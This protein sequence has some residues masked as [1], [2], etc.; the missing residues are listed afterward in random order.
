LKAK[1]NLNVALA[2]PARLNPRDLFNDLDN[3][4]DTLGLNLVQLSGLFNSQA[5]VGLVDHDIQGQITPEASFII[6][7]LARVA[8]HIA[9]DPAVFSLVLPDIARLIFKRRLMPLNENSLIKIA[10]YWCAPPHPFF[11]SHLPQ[12]SA[13]DE[14]E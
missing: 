1:R 8:I 9:R 2:I 5:S 4:D 7:W 6:A 13:R 11:S 3:D 12:A 10:L 14:A